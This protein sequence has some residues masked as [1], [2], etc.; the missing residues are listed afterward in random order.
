MK[1]QLENNKP[2]IAEDCFVAASADLIGDVIM[3]QGASVWFNCVLRADNASITV[4]KNSNVQDGSVL[5]VDPGFP[6]TIG[7]GVTVGH[8]VMLHGCTI[9]D[10]SLIGINAVVLNG[11]QIG[12]N[13]IIGANALVTEGTIIGDGQMALGSPA[14]VVKEVSEGTIAMLKAGADHYVH[15]G[16]RYQESLTCLDQ[17]LD[18]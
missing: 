17:D 14:K 9:G 12:K 13:C 10:N 15:N 18:T 2:D 1:Y 16:K 6:L 8:K 3:H 7:E 5:H 11:A 4:G